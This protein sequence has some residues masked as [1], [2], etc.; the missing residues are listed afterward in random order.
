MI[1]NPADGSCAERASGAT[2]RWR[3]RRLRAWHRHERMTVA[4]E[5]ATALHHSAQPVE[6]PREGV[7]GEKYHAPVSPPTTTVPSSGSRCTSA[8]RTRPTTGTDALERPLGTRRLVS[9][10]S[11]WEGRVTEAWCG[12]STRS[13][14]AL[15][16]L[17]LRCLLGDGLRG[18]GLG[19][20]SPLLG[21]HSS[22]LQQ[23]WSWRVRLSSKAWSVVGFFWLLGERGA[24]EFWSA[25]RGCDMGR[26]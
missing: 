19:I 6:A 18:E 1:Q 14:V 12:T 13:L 16:M 21:C 23:E 25:V 3:E 24:G 15:R 7:E 8:K 11:G 10:S 5:L 26:D 4:M 20:P 17:S 22:C 2:V 9:R